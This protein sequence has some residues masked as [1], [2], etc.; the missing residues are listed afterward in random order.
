[1]N[2]YIGNSWE[3]VQLKPWET[4]ALDRVAI[5][6][7]KGYIAS[8]G[9]RQAVNVALQLQQPLLVTGDPGTGKSSLADSVAYDLGLSS[10]L[11][12]FTTTTASARDVFY[13]YDSLSHFQDAN[14]SRM[15]GI[16]VE[17]YISYEALGLAILRSNPPEAVNE[18][19]PPAWQVQ[20]QEC[21]VVLID[22]IDKAPRDF[23]NDILNEIE[24]L[25]FQVRETGKAFSADRAFWPIVVMT[26]NSEN[27]LPDPFL[28]RCV[29]YHIEF[30]GPSEL[31]EIVRRRLP[32]V[33]EK[34][35]FL[36]GAIR[37]FSEIRKLALRKRPA[38]AEFLAWVQV[39][40]RAGVNPESP[41]EGDVEALIC[42]YSILAKNEGD[43]K[44]LRDRILR[45]DG[46]HSAATA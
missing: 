24:H 8:P 3:K 6:G 40:E 36:D 45:T 18:Q 7:P 16:H 5:T 42:S 31:R 17:Q 38:T 2:R 28:R 41:R 32:E 9:L 43:Y 4:I 34:E 13:R 19:L 27:T 26:S 44:L 37:Q 39:L 21:S 25:R 11:R 12:F 1:M 46:G 22:E 23:P 35:L 14:I 30:P 29:F 20:K 15:A 33:S 10:A